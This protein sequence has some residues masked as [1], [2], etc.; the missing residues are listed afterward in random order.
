MSTLIGPA[1]I[2]RLDDD[3]LARISRGDRLGGIALSAGVTITLGA[4]AY[5]IAFG[6]WRALEQAAYSAVK[7]PALLLSVAACTLGLS[8]ML[9]SILRSK[10]SIRQTAVSIL[11]S[12]AITSAVLGAMAPVSIVVALIA[13]PP[14]PFGNATPFVLAAVFGVVAGS[15]LIALSLRAPASCT[16]VELGPSGLALR[17]AG[18]MRVVSWKAIASV[19]AAGPE[20][21]V[22]LRPDQTLTGDVLRLACKDPDTAREL[23]RRVDAERTAWRSGPFRT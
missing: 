17:E 6:I 16:D 21:H 14:D 4:G 19:C 13:P 10:L 8:V 7:L 23:A 2:C 1:A 15:A 20:I 22:T 3:L 12:L 18:A 9:A 5:G 11:L